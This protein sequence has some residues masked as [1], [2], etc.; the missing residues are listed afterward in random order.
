MTPK[1][2]IEHY[3]F[4]T[5]I[6]GIGL[7]IVIIVLGFVLW[8]IGLIGIIFV[9]SISVLLFLGIALGNIMMESIVSYRAFQDKIRKNKVP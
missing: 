8:T 2:L 6:S 4:R 5:L 7:A 9:L 1:K 3:K